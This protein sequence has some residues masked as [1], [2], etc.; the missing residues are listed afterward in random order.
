[1]NKFLFF[2]DKKEPEEGVKK[3]DEDIK[4]KMKA[5]F[6]EELMRRYAITSTFELAVGVIVPMMKY[7]EDDIVVKFYKEERDTD[8][9]GEDWDPEADCEYLNV[10]MKG[11]GETL[12]FCNVWSNE[13]N[14]FVWC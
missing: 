3:I 8:L 5:F 2:L 13:V 6:V 1:M 14:N 9:A 10:A 11:P 12:L 4:A 7:P